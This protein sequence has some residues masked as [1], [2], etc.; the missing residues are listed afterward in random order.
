MKKV[1]I[2]KASNREHA[3]LPTALKKDSIKK[4]SNREQIVAACIE[5]LCEKSTFKVAKQLTGTLVIVN[6]QNFGLLKDCCR[7][8]AGV[9]SLVSPSKTT[10]ERFWKVYL[11]PGFA[12]AVV[13]YAGETIGIFTIE[14]ISA[15]DLQGVPKRWRCKSFDRKSGVENFVEVQGFEMPQYGDRDAARVN[16]IQQV[17]MTGWQHFVATIMTLKKVNGCII[18][19]EHGM[20]HET[21]F[22]GTKFADAVGMKKSEE[23]FKAKGLGLIGSFV[24][25]K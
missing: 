15:V 19:Y 1:S 20:E 17:V 6:K 10:S 4:A 9:D 23:Y 25:R 24:L 13:R 14:C 7:L 12:A 16:R 11:K 22:G 3:L 8:F 5:Q 2:R 18:V 21:I